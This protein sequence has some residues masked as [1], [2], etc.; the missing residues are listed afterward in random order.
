MRRMRS[1]TAALAALL[2]FTPLAALTWPAR[3]VNAQ[4][5]RLTS[6]VQQP[7]Y[8][9]SGVDTA[10]SVVINPAAMPFMESWGV[11]YLHADSGPGERMAGRGDGFYAATPILFGIAAGI[12]VDSVRP[13]P[14]TLDPERTM[15]SIALGW[16]TDDALAVGAGL[17]ILASSD[18][19]LNG[20]VSLD[21]S[22]A[23]RP[24]DYLGMTFMAR[25][26]VGPRLG[27]SIE[28]VPRSFVLGAALRPFGTRALTLDA[29]G[30]IDERGEIGARG[31]AEITI[32]Y[33][34][35]VLAAIEAEQ[36]AS[37]TPDVRMVGG[38]ALD[39]SMI[40]AGGGV[41][42]G[43]GYESAP[44]WYVQGHIEGAHREGIPRGD[45]VQEVVLSG[46]GAR[47]VIN[48]VR[49]LE[50]ALREDRIRGVLIRPRGSGLSLAYAQEIRILI[51]RLHEAGKR[52]VCHFDDAAGAEWYAC[53]GADRILLDPA[54][55]VRLQGVSTEMY[56]LGDLLRNVGVRADFV[57]I[58]QWKSA[59]E[60]YHNG[61]MSPRNRA[62][63][64][65]V[66]D[67]AYR[68][69]LFD[70]AP[71]RDLT[72]AQLAERIDLGPHL[73]RSAL[74]RGLVE[75]LADEH[76]MA[77]ELRAG[78]GASYARDR[79]FPWEVPERWGD[80][81]HVGVVVVDGSIT[82][83][84]NENIPIIGIHTSG[85]RTIVRAIDRFANDPSIVAIVLRVDSPGGS[86][87]ASDQ[88]YRAVLRARRR[89][90]VIASLGATAASGGYYIAAP[91]HE[92]WANPTTVTGSIGVWFGK[93]DFQPLGE[94]I[95]VTLEQL[96]RGRNA[97]ATSLYR[98][99][100]AGE[101]A[102]LAE[103]VREWYRQ[104]LRRVAR[105]RAMSV[106]E[107]DR[108]G[109]GRLW[110]G[111]QAIDNGLVDHLGGLDSAIT[112]ARRAAG[113][114][115][116]VGV[117]VVPDRPSTVLDYVLGAIGLGAAS[118]RAEDIEAQA[119]LLERVAPELRAA[120]VSV[121]TMRQLGSGAPMA[122]MP[123]V[124]VPH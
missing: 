53:A 49:T 41:W 63:R 81:P 36:L 39:W 75:A 111:D 43:D 16:Q 97:G 40:G 58:G 121:V 13:A 112:A 122:M 107:V 68:R 12:G 64:E 70:A 118:A 4:F 18:L 47:G 3:V 108:L 95:G 51:E 109:R 103:S 50:Y 71:D 74:D 92:I 84:E 30:V 115:P 57:R 1:R 46:V 56:L 9:L 78:F 77:E 25:D 66:L 6:P 42:V 105:A 27:G 37:N 10:E 7:G 55:G 45:Y 31:A 101:R 94:M 21:L 91:A 124:V 83:G 69:L 60:E 20:V 54:G 33:V 11:S 52:V 117:I 32:P 62:Q 22:A 123:Q 67:F 85:S 14:L 23:W 120:L 119:E 38:L 80:R 104:F 110:M 2:V 35:R 99:F 98:P 100:T 28:T 93:V 76:D 61:A 15:V 29:G 26:V 96:G 79:G 17:R 90:P 65:G 87:L 86:V 88:I 116:E 48:V 5:T 114:G 59:I 89:K 72:E 102:V 8:S 82:D 44:G 24:V 73:P 113:V 106:Q 19:R 34:G